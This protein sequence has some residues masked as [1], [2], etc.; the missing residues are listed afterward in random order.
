MGRRQRQCSTP[1]E[2]PGEHGQLALFAEVN[3][4]FRQFGASFFNRLPRSP[5]VY[6]MLDET[7]RIL[8]VGKSKNLRQRLNSYKT[9]QPERV[10]KK[11]WRLLAGVR[12]IKWE[13][14]AT[15]EAALLRENFLLRTFKPPYNKVN[16][17]PESYACIGLRRERETLHLHFSMSPKKARGEQWYGAFKARGLARAANGSMGRLLWCVT[18]T[19]Q[20]MLDLPILFLRKDH[21]TYITVPMPL[22]EALW[23]ETQVDDYF[24]GKSRKMLDL[25]RVRLE[26]G[27]E[28]EKVL[29][30]WLQR[31]LDTLE[32]FYVVGPARNADLAPAFIEQDEMDDL[33]VR[34][35][36]LK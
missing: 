8:Y 9:A 5:G 13:K 7:K 17:R 35:D 16:T 25:L 15:E 2:M 28:R 33:L 20:R 18:H 32:Q 3:P 21:P 11:V 10:S 22:E 31:A 27:P 36:M 29:E 12:D 23:W 1:P 6:I 26:K 24:R 34:R 4:L 19:P 30:Q 14:C